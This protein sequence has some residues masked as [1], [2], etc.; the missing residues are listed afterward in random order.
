M[1]WSHH[2]LIFNHYH[3]YAH[4]NSSNFSLWCI[5][6]LCTYNFMP[7][8]MYTVR[9]P[10]SC[11]NTLLRYLRGY[12]PWR[13]PSLRVYVKK[14]K[15]FIIFMLFSLFICSVTLRQHGQPLPLLVYQ[16][17][18]KYPKNTRPGWAPK[19]LIL[20]FRLRVPSSLKLSTITLNNYQGLESVL[21]KRLV[22][23]TQF[24]VCKFVAETSP[25]GAT[26]SVYDSL[27][28]TLQCS[29]FLGSP[30]KLNEVYHI[31]YH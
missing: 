16:G 22:H 24:H 4:F 31:F 12:S 10:N 14:D 2:K 30:V 13:E 8:F 15:A 20:F 3:S 5:R 26:V 6:H 17:W 28:I 21:K 29:S 11:S 1:A 9:Y 7:G 27:R 25:R 23:R 18:E 19:L